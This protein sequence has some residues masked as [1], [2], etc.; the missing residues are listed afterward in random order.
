LEFLNTTRQTRFDI[1][2]DEPFK[3]NE[4]DNEIDKKYQSL[5]KKEIMMKKAY[6]SLVD[7][8]KMKTELIK[9][10]NDLMIYEKT[11]FYESLKINKIKK[12]EN[13]NNL[14]NESMKYFEKMSETQMN[15][16]ADDINNR[17]ILNSVDIKFR[18]QEE[19][20]N[21]IESEANKKLIQLLSIIKLDQEKRIF[22]SE[23]DF[24]NKEELFK[25]KFL[26]DKWKTEDNSDFKREEY[27]ANL[28]Q[29]ELNKFK[30]NNDN[31]TNEG[32]LNLNENE[33]KLLIKQVEKERN[34]R[35][36]DHIDNRLNNN[37]AKSNPKSKSD[38]YYESNE[39][40]NKLSHDNAY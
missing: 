13:L 10:E 15:I 39:N 30:I 8:E 31:I 5:C 20:L 27:L 23:S 29:Y 6:E 37:F 19:E 14:I 11:K 21:N 32:Y 24:K 40:R 34:E 1:I 35:K 16:F 25:N 9:R 33:R 4:A 38:S 28:K 18:L 12:I 3:F 7:K 26:E 17:K 2:S 22:N 36:N